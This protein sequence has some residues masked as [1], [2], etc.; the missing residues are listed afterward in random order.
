MWQPPA[1]ETRYPARADLGKPDASKGLHSSRRKTL[2]KRSGVRPTEVW[3]LV[4]ES[5]YT[6]LC[7]FVVRGLHFCTCFTRRQEHSGSNSRLLSQHSSRNRVSRSQSR[8]SHCIP[9]FDFY[10]GRLGR[11]TRLARGSWN[12]TWGELEGRI[13]WFDSLR[14]AA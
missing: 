12:V 1:R 11:Q 5:I 6:S 10:H 2:R 3:Y 14:T 8:Q 4:S 7:Q 9:K 13:L